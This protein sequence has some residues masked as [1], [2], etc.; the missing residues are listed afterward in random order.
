MSARRMPSWTRIATG[1]LNW[2]RLHWWAWRARTMLGSGGLIAI[3]VL[4]LG[5]LFGALGLS[6]FSATETASKAVQVPEPDRVASGA[7]KAS[8]SELGASDR[9]RQQWSQWPL[10]NQHSRDLDRLVAVAQTHGVV[11]ETGRV[12]RVV[13][14]DAPV[15]QIQLEVSLNQPWSQVRTFLA[16]A[17][18]RMPH[19][20]LQSV[21]LAR[22]EPGAPRVNAQLVFSWVY[23]MPQQARPQQGRPQ[24]ARQQPERP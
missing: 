10:E 4:V 11:F 5:L 16:G 18:N 14:E 22:D 15:V 9:L 19:L 1:P 24:Q 23:R 7:Q 2:E 12:R 13:H 20:A 21:R 17:L 6:R 3:A 8:E